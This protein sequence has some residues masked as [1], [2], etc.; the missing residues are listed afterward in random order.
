M[1]ILFTN[2]RLNIKPG[3]TVSGISSQAETLNVVSGKV[4][5][6]VEGSPD[7]YWLSA[8]ESMV[9]AADRLVVIEAFGEDSQIVLP[10]LQC[11]SDVR[12]AFDFRSALNRH[13][14]PLPAEALAQAGNDEAAMAPSS[15]KSTQFGYTGGLCQ[16]SEPQQAQT[17]PA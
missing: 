1:R 5:L 17:V 16:Q 11:D 3:T 7:D 8:G 15:A 2:S 6:T 13:S 12:R 10:H 4:W 9:V 14:Q